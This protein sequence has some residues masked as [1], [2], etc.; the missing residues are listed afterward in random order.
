MS[1]NSGLTAEQINAQNAAARSARAA[2]VNAQ[3]PG[4]S[5]T[6]ATPAKSTPKRTPAKSTPKG[7]TPKGAT[8]AK[9]TPRAAAPVKLT[10]ARS[11]K[12][13]V[14]PGR[15]AQHRAVAQMLITLGADFYAKSARTGVELPV[16]GGKRG[17]TIHVSREQ[18]LTSI[19]QTFGYTPHPLW[20]KRLGARDV[21]RPAPVKRAS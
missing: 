3:S 2:Q 14:S 18:L 1:E 4:Q 19:K 9:S 15:N 8:P 11:T 21:G 13:G 17:E 12:D 7:A 10:P 5:V 20:D 16:P 6:G